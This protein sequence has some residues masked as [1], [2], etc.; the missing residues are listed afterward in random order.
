MYAKDRSAYAQ[1]MVHGNF[2]QRR[3]EEH[4]I[5]S[6]STR[7]C[8]AEEPWAEYKR[9]MPL[10]SENRGVLWDIDQMLQGVT[11]QLR[12]EACKGSSVVRNKA[13]HEI[14]SQKGKM[15]APCHGAL[16]ESSTYS[17][18]LER[19]YGSWRAT[20]EPVKQP[21]SSSPQQYPGLQ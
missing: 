20:T 11:A 3:S 19:S 18:S 13:P 15:I 2:S 6:L 4:N 16:V 17:D 14:H 5:I 1:G 7:E 9:I 21:N 10:H 8:D 12:I